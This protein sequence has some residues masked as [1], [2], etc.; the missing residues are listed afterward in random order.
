MQNNNFAESDKEVE[1]KSSC[2][3]ALTFVDFAGNN[4][5]I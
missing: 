5:K 3:F 1:K 4:N 2:M